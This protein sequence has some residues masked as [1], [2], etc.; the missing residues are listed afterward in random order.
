VLTVDLWVPT[1]GTPTQLTCR[2]ALNGYPKISA[3]TSLYVLVQNV[4]LRD[5][6]YFNFSIISLTLAGPNPV[7][8][9]AVIVSHVSNF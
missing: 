2:G 1:R 5:Q 9:A 8:F 6:L 7:I 3:F 4:S